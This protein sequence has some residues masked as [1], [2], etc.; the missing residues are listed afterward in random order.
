MMGFY[1][2]VPENCLARELAEVEALLADFGERQ[3]RH[4]KDGSALA[5]DLIDTIKGLMPFF[6][7]PVPHVLVWSVM[8]PRFRECLDI[9][10]PAAVWRFVAW[11]VGKLLTETHILVYLGGPVSKRLVRGLTSIERV[12][13]RGDFRLPTDMAE[14][15]HLSPPA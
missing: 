4:S 9:S 10:R 15:F 8:E 7:K 13:E 3:F 5:H 6:L 11:L 12:G 2:G 14:S 1:L